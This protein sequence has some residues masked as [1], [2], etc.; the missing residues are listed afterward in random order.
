MTRAF[1]LSALLVA[2]ALAGC[3]TVDIDQQLATT[4][5]EAA[6]FTGGQL[7]LARTDEQRA[8]Q[9][10]AADRLLA[11]PLGQPQ[12]VQLALAGSPAVQAAIAQRWAEAATA[13]Q[14]ARLA[15][16]MFSFERM[17][18][19]PELELTRTLSFGLFELLTLPARAAQAERRIAASQVQLT[20]SAVD[21]VT[22]VRQTWVRAVAAQ[23]SLGYARQV[24][25][26]AE[27]SAELARRMQ[28]VGNWNRL[29]RARQQLFYADATTQL[30]LAEQQAASARAAL[31]RLLGLDAAQAARLQL[32]DRLPDLPKAPLAAQAL[33]QTALD[34]R[35]DVRLARARYNQS[36][37]A[38]GLG[39]VTSLIDVEL[40]LKRKSV[41]PDANADRESGRGWELG[42]R[43]PIFDFGDVQRDA[44]SA[45]T[46]AA[47]NQL[48]AVRRTAGAQLQDSYATYRTAWD[49]AHHYQSEVI[50]LRQLMQEEN[51][52]RYNGMLIGVFE[53]LQ[54]ARE[55]VQSVIA[56]IGAQQQFWQADAALQASLIGQPTGTLLSAST[57]TGAGDAAAH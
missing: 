42:V 36:A 56:A 37:H 13:A 8:Q 31:V 33:N 21:Q 39:R 53:L 1:R 54:D 27:V 19:G 47:A 16:P 48:L 29:T 12:A 55:Q 4:N 7:A 14:S 2:A 49:V 11:A 15:N 50:P 45:Q 25:A 9:Q 30:A 28:A 43:L 20:A 10:A 17:R 41:W 6:A 5:Q 24:Q 40:D 3:A 35:L 46:L 34:T 51:L 26:S 57:N 23:Q 22:Q 52:L 32:P 38:H 44:M 18:G